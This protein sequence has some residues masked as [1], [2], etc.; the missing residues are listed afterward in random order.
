MLIVLTLDTSDMSLVSDASLG[1]LSSETSGLNSR[2]NNIEKLHIIQ[3]KNNVDKEKQ[4]EQCNRMPNIRNKLY[5]KNQNKKT[6]HFLIKKKKQYFSQN[7]PCIKLTN[8][9]LMSY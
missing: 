5:W 4:F 3:M 8:M 7:M 9:N 2:Q 1:K 6:L